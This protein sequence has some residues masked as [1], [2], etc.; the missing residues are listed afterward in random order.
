MKFTCNTRVEKVV[1]INC[2]KSIIQI[3]ISICRRKTIVKTKKGE[4]V[5]KTRENGL[6]YSSILFIKVTYI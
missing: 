4:R 1:I 2:V 6:I 3:R 5:I